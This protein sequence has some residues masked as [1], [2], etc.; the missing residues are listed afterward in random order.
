M[1]NF[2][3]YLSQTPGNKDWGVNI[4][5]SGYHQI[6][7]GDIYPPAGHPN[8]HLFEWSEGRSLKGFYMVYIP[9]G[10]GIL[11]TKEKNFE[12]NPGDMLMLYNNEWHRYKPNSE[13]GWEEYWIG[14]EGDFFEDSIKQEVFPESK[15]YVKHLGYKEEIIFLMSQSLELIRRNTN[16]YRKILSGILIQLLAYTITSEEN[17][18]KTGEEDIA[19]KTIK[20]IRTQLYKEIDFEELASKFNLSY[21]R[22]RTIFKQQTGIAP[23]QYLIQE[24]IQN[25][26]RLLSNTDKGIKEIASLTGFRSV[27]YFSRIFRQ[28]TGLSP[29]EVRRKK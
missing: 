15:S 23:Q 29:T 13:E 18:F 22:F 8:S 24:R 2:F 14:F 7:P 20:T 9:T 3:K 25:A 17:E 6:R 5:T 28:K 16:G 12:V 27:Y 26:H 10:G 1:K 11:E 4:I 21:S 19:N